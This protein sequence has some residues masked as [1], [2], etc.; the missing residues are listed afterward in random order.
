[1]VPLGTGRSG[2]SQAAQ[3]GYA[4]PLPARPAEDADAPRFHSASAQA[5]AIEAK[6]EPKRPWCDGG[7]VVGRG[8]GFCEVNL[9]PERRGAPALLALY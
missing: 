8:A 6:P 7:Q 5:P 2:S 9:A 1:M 3:P 4:L